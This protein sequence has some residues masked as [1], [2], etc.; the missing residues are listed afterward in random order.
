MDERTLWLRTA[1]YYWRTNL[2]VVLGVVA[3]GAALTGALLVGDSMRASLRAAA[4][5]RL[6]RIDAALV[7]NRFFGI[8]LADRLAFEGAARSERARGSSMPV[9]SGG[10][11]RPRRGDATGFDDTRTDHGVGDMGT[12]EKGGDA[13]GSGATAASLAQPS[14]MPLILLAGAVSNP[15]TEARVNRVNVGGI[16]ERLARLFGD[17]R[18]AGVIRGLD[19][20][21]V[22]L[23]E[24]LAR[25]LGVGVG[26]DVLLHMGRS[27]AI[28]PETLLGRRD[29]GTAALRLTVRAVLPATG[30]GGF[31]LSARQAR[32][33]NAFVPLATLQRSLDQPERANAILV[34]QS[35]AANTSSG[36]DRLNANLRA[37]L[38]LADVGLS[39]RVI[40]PHGYVLLES[41]SLLIEPPIEQA[42]LAAAQALDAEAAAVLSYLANEIALL[43]ADDAQTPAGTIP[44]STVAALE[45]DSFAQRAL[46]LADGRPPRLTDGEILLNEWAA[47]DLGVRPG[48]TIRLRY[49]ITGPYGELATREATFALR[50][51]VRLTGAAADPHFV[52][53][54]RGVTD[55]ANMAAW[56]PPFPVDLKQVRERDE[57]Y[58]RRYRTTPKAFVTLADGE[59]LWAQQEQRFGRI[60]SLRLRPAAG[61]GTDLPSLAAAFEH[62]LLARLDPAALGLWFQPVRAQ[63]LA[64]SAGSTDFGGLFLGF[65]SFLIAS[66]A[67][68]VA[69]LFRLNVERRASQVGL[70]LACGFWRGGIARLLLAEG[71]VLATI[72]SAASLVGAAGYAAL[73]LTGLGWWWSAA[74]NAP[75]LRLDLSAGSL[76]GGF[77]GTF[78]LALLSIGWSLRGLTRRSPR[79]LLLGSVESDAS[80]ARLRQSTALAVGVA[81]LGIAVVVTAYATAGNVRTQTTAFFGGGAMTLVA[82]LAFVRYGLSRQPLHVIHAPGRA[83]LLRLGARNVPRHTGRSMLTVSL[84]ACATFLIT[85]LSAFHLSSPDATR[86]DSG[87]GGYALY[88]ESVVPLVYDM[89]AAAGREKLNMTPAAQA[90]LAGVRVMPFRLSGG[91]ATSCLNLYRAARPRILGA[92]EALIERGGFRFTGAM[93][94][95][96][97][98][99]GNP[100]RLLHHRFADG[101]IP[102]IGD[103]AAVRWQLHLDLGEGLAITDERGRTVL[104]RFVALLAGSALQDELIV[105]EDNF[106]RL[107]PSLSG[108]G[109]FLIEAP[110]ERLAVVEQTLERA[111]APFGF[112]AAR[113]AERLRDYFAVQNTYVAIFQTLGGLGLVLGAVGLVA[114]L[115]RTV[116]QRR[117]ELALLRAIGYPAGAIQAL[118]LAENAVLIIAGLLCGVLPAALAVGPAAAARSTGVPWLMVT[119]MLLG[120]LVVGVGAGRLA[121]RS[122]L[123]APLLAGLRSE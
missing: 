1:A 54:Y 94:L 28:S 112:D 8:A 51:V 97:R 58:W 123:R 52:P 31:A 122:T 22:I 107:F 13:A 61:G 80:A 96:D 114:V 15:L 35:G 41:Q 59:R 21:G 105:A 78:L 17:A 38:R 64:A 69:L 90:A 18:A 11:R 119:A 109:F 93:K 71:A 39:L 3:G 118:V 9:A 86:R 2:A 92:P 46:V 32:P 20:R 10:Q 34:G 23:N 110:P 121:L 100:W 50:G 98:Q 25:E 72:G 43:R 70:L 120:V 74:V 99:R 5:E 27:S 89:N 88:A 116:W 82:G 85:S 63:A 56:D 91:D 81:A 115:L 30:L 42:A 53:E 101:A 68:L 44:Y 95:D 73:M 12:D 113:T 40:E 83:A 67:M 87:A 6:G 76:I 103:E 79:A 111:L 108:H 65:S 26:D 36:V 77:A 7:A 57:D 48:D 45:P 33:F 24:P 47:D 29:D 37:A 4:L 55:A 49:Y 75:F 62:E 117:G 66:A 16:D 14:S 104:L 84:I 60:T 19:T 106:V 102:V